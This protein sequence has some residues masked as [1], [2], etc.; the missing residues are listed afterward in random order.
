MSE[1][2]LNARIRKRRHPEYWY[3]Q[4]HAE[5]LSDRQCAPNILDRNFTSLMPLRK[6]ATDVTWVSFV[7][8]KLYLSA[9]MDLFNHEII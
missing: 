8:G 2:L 3:R 5:R 4:R 7:G 1:Y 9:L 6:L